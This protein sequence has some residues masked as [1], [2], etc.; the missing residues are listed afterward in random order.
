MTGLNGTPMVSF[1][2]AFTPEQKWDLVAYVL[3][4]RGTAPEEKKP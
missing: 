2:H 4:L 3:S 1:A